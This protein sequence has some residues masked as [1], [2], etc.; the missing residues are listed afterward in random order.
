MQLLH[1]VHCTP[2]THLKAI[3]IIIKFCIEI[4]IFFLPCLSFHL[5]K[6]VCPLTSLHIS[7]IKKCMH[8]TVV[9]LWFAECYFQLS[10]LLIGA[11]P[12]NCSEIT[13][14]FW[15]E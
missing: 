5:R 14:D 7:L 11:F 15:C 9:T 13:E 1:V 6:L 3:I 8:L 2:P 4:V 10:M 12:L